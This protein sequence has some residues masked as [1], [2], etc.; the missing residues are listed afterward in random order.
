MN[1]YLKNKD[2]V[3]TKT[4]LIEC[5]KYLINTILKLM[6]IIQTKK[7][8]IQTKPKVSKKERETGSVNC[9]QT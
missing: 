7:I 1:L 5:Q 6:R 8:F 3:W 9:A 4:Q 2:I